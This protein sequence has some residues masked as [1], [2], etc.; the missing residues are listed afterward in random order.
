MAKMPGEALSL[1]G[2]LALVP[3]R[4]SVLVAMLNGHNLDYAWFGQSLGERPL[5]QNSWLTVLSSVALGGLI[6]LAQLKRRSDLLIIPALILL[7]LVQIFLIPRP[8]WVHHW[9]GI[10]PLPHLAVAVFFHTLGSVI[11]RERA[12]KILASMIIVGAV[13][14]NLSL[15]QGYQQQLLKTG[16]IGVWTDAIYRLNETL[17]DD[18][19]SNPICVMDWG[20][21]NQLLFLSKGQL[22][23]QEPFWNY[24]ESTTP[25]EPLL[26]LV[27]DPKNIFLLHTDSRESFAK[28]REALFEA[29]RQGGLQAHIEKTF[30]ERTGKDI[31]EIV[32]FRP[33]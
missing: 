24:L 33:E 12:V 32:T 15:W 21:S 6:I 11:S 19:P 29:A 28:P 17:H 14:V 31:F 16:G 27:R 3:E 7:M 20:I 18:Y 2:L 10:Y 1:S 13:C 26:S 23:L 5:G 8:V 25:Q 22:H 9:I 4:F 30:Q